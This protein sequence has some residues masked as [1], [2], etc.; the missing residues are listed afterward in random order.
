MED[1]RRARAAL[2]VARAGVV[3]L[4]RGGVA[5]LCRFHH[6]QRR[7][8]G[9]PQPLAVVEV[10]HLHQGM[11][12]GRMLQLDVDFPYPC[13]HAALR[14]HGRRQDGTL[15]IQVCSRDAQV[16]SANHDIAG[17]QYLAHP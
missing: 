1:R 3:V 16:H 15:C 6:Q 13:R 4:L 11:C 17:L 14:R 7:L 9:Q 2:C 5:Q 8:L 10:Q 12:L